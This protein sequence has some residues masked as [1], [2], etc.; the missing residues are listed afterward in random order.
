MLEECAPMW[1]AWAVAAWATPF[2]SLLLVGFGFWL[3]G[4]QG[5][6]G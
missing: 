6:G 4:R 5:D 3:R 1:R 2:V